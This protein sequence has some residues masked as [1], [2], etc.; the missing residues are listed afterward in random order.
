[1]SKNPDRI[2]PGEWLQVLI[3]LAIGG[4]MA[5]AMYQNDIARGERPSFGAYG[6]AALFVGHYGMRA[7]VFLYIWARYDWETAKSMRLF[8][9]FPT[10]HP[11][12]LDPRPQSAPRRRSWRMPALMS[13][14]S[15]P[16]PPAQPPR[17]SGHSAGSPSQPGRLPP[18]G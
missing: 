17:M 13:R 15:G 12:S 11:L 8:A 7:L 3:S 16:Q 14:R 6:L 18:P 5:M 4:Y 9:L 2:T 10:E 1:M